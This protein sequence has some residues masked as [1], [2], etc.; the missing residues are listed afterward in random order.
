MSG[1]M[2][3]DVAERDAVYLWDLGGGRFARV[4]STAHQL[5][6]LR[7]D[8]VSFDEIARRLGG[9]GAA[10]A[11]TTHAGLVARLDELRRRPR[12]DRA[13]LLRLRVLSAARVQAIA[14]R[15]APLYRRTIA[16]P[17]ALL[18]LA[19]IA[20]SL[21]RGGLPA[22]TPGAIAVGYALFIASL[23]VHELGHAS[24]S[25]W[26][27]RPPSEI[28]A[29]L[30]LVYPAFYSDVS[31]AWAL[32]RGARVVVDLGGVYFQLAFIAALGVGWRAS[33]WAPFGAAAW[34]SLAS[35]A[36]SINPI[37]RFDG[38]WVLSDLIGVANLD[39]QPL[40]LLGIAWSR[41]R[42]RRVARLPWSGA[43]TAAVAIYGIVSQT[44]WAAFAISLGP[45]AWR[46]GRRFGHAVATLAA[47]HAAADLL[48][49]ARAALVVVAALWLA[50]RF[51]GAV[52]RTLRPA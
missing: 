40:R 35:A 43:T 2:R 23:L 12:R 18:S 52:A 30:Y 44:I 24:A 41:L 50:A 47:H 19:A 3:L 15:L 6:R 32:R 28:G 29:A 4:S 46:E 37:F 17:L 20:W 25:A 45:M 11:A 14:R 1:D 16:L 49:M 38:Y 33:G 48:A 26:F 39:S 10:W 22:A 27:G 8:G 21:P 34:M 31:Q 7:A 5:L 9:S 51:I 13:F 36:L 42:R